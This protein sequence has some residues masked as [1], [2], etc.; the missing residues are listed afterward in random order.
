M[1]SAGYL[2][3]GITTLQT[4]LQNF[5]DEGDLICFTCMSIK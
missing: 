5:V 2:F 3:D 1:E 4:T